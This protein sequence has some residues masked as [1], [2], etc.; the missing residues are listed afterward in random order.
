MAAPAT[1]RAAPDLPSRML[2]RTRIS[3]RATTITHARHMM[4]SRRF[5][6]P[7]RPLTP[8]AGVRGAWAVPGWR[9]RARQVPADQHGGDRQPAE[10]EDSARLRSSSWLRSNGAASPRQSR[11]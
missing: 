6:Q 11:R 7:T 10:L 2:P 1:M 4:A 9:C 8:G 5:A 3:S